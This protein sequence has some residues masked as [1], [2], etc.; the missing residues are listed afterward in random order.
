M[1]A[2]PDDITFPVGAQSEIKMDGERLRPR[3]QTG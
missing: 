3:E 2:N 1:A